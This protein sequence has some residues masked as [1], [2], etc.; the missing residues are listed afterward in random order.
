MVLVCG[1]RIEVSPVLGPAKWHD[2]FELPL[3]LCRSHKVWL[4]RCAGQVV[5]GIGTQDERRQAEQGRPDL[6]ERRAERML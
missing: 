3:R 5:G 4:G 2:Y 6:G 1:E